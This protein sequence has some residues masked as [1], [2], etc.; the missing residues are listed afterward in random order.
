MKRVVSMVLTLAMFTALFLSQVV[1]AENMGA[2][3][4]KTGSNLINNVS[5]VADVIEARA[6]QVGGSGSSIVWQKDFLVTVQIQNL[7]DSPVLVNGLKFSLSFSSGSNVQL[8]SYESY[9]S[10]VWISND[11]NY[12]FTIVPSNDFS[13]SN[14]I[15]VPP[16]ESLWVVG[17][18][19]AQR[20]SDSNSNFN[21]SAVTVPSFTT[22][23]SDNYPYGATVNW[24]PLISA[25]DQYFN[26]QHVDN[27]NI[28]TV[29]GTIKVDSSAAVTSLSNIISILTYSGNYPSTPSAATGLTTA[30]FTDTSGNI[31]VTA[32]RRVLSPYI[33]YDFEL[34]STAD[35]PVVRGTVVYPVVLVMSY[36]NTGTTPYRIG[37]NFNISS[38]LPSSSGIYYPHILDKNEQ[39]F[40]LVEVNNTNTI[41]EGQR[42]S[43]NVY[44]YI[45]VGYFR[46]YYYIEYRVPSGT[47]ITFNTFDSSSFNFTVYGA[48]GSD[49]YVPYDEYQILRDL[50]SSYASS[51]PGAS[52]N[53]SA[54]D[55]LTQ[56]SDNVHSQ[57][58]Q[59]FNQNSQA[60]Q[61]VGLSNYRFDQNQTGGIGAVSNDFT[62][63]FNA[64]GG[65]NSV[66]IF[67]MTLSLALMILR[68]VRPVK[69]DKRSDDG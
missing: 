15:V 49:V 36:Q 61:N 20:V 65:F 9:S 25:I 50:Y 57:E 40:S 44:S 60:L 58:Q 5:V 32:R 27:N 6:T 51:A 22:A 68:H 7:V 64:L 66:F 1:F 12:F 54:S 29:L 45:P 33:D 28:L 2:D 23:R 56:Q 41:F 69:R 43:S 38:L 8:I 59:F 30:S 4:W 35:F 46:S 37:I 3:T 13:Y 21:L 17:V 48:S 10:D 52:S 67:S 62:A 24:A 55:S 26:T 31:T 16:S 18:I 42:V 34:D 47:S 53:G 11:G 19:T 14:G 39:W 63:V